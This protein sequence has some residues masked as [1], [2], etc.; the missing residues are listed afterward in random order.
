MDNFK[1]QGSRRS[2]SLNGMSGGNRQAGG[3]LPPRPQ[4]NGAKFNTGNRLDNFRGSE[5]FHASQQPAMQPAQAV[6]TGRNPRRGPDGRID[7]SLSPA[8]PKPRKKRNYK[9]IILRSTAGL[10]VT[11]MAVVG[12]L[13]G[14]GYLKLHQIFKG[15]AQGAAALQDN[16]DP[17]KLRGEGDGR[18]NILLLGKGGTGHDGPDLTDTI[19]IASID[20][21]NKQAA[22]LSIPRD[23]WVTPSGM[24]EGKINAVYANAKYA[25][26]NKKQ[27]ASQAEQAGLNAIQK[28]I[29]EDIGIP[30]HYHVMMDFDGF[31]QAIDTVGGVDINVPKELAVR[32]NMYDEIRHKPYLLDVKA[33]TSHFDGR[34]GLFF[35]RTRHTS[36]RG[37]FD[38]SERQRL[39]LVALKDKV[40]SAGTYSNPVKISG[41][42]DAFGNHIQSDLSINDVM[43]L[44]DIMKNINSSAIQSVGLA[45][46]PNNY[47]TTASLNGL[48]I[49]RPRAGLYDF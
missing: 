26:L 32:D 17:N 34:R 22:L 14:K 33:G 35:A 40:L 28:E 47:V 23:L 25:A 30:I 31:Q 6:S 39:L 7:L 19:M 5:G 37:D 24:G 11:V 21:V 1:R 15:G 42:I 16:V 46:P 10:V 3:S 44:Y 12:F 48:S 9:R 27:S 29:Q 13:F 45:D 8:P 43:R 41:L 20:P 4:L 2:N 18:V 36:A 49:V 38:R